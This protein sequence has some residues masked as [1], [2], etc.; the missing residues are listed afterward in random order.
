MYN[1]KL[2]YVVP[3]KKDEEVY[4]CQCDKTAKPPYC[5]GQHKKTGK[6]PFI[7]T[8]KKDQTLFVCGCGKSADIPWCD[9]SHNKLSHSTTL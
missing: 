3:I 6:R 1:N 7:Y 2:P 9:N 5:D 8:A 4:L